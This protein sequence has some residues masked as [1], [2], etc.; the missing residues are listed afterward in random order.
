MSGTE[1]HA[2]QA[3]LVVNAD[4]AA[5]NAAHGPRIPAAGCR[6]SAWVIPTDEEAMFVR[7]TPAALRR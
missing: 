2:D 4:D 6:A 1:R 7:H 3:I 5:G